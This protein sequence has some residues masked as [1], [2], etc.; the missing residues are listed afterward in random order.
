MKLDA[1]HISNIHIV[2]SVKSLLNMRDNHIL[3]YE[4]LIISLQFILRQFR[5][6]QY[7]S[8]YLKWTGINFKCSIFV[9]RKGS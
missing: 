7:Y 4:S 5:M 8:L 3:S 9:Q 1:E 6:N 2:A